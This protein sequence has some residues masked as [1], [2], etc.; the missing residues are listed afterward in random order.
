MNQTHSE[1]RNS[2][3]SVSSM[4][5]STN[6]AT[7]LLFSAKRRPTS[8]SSL[9]GI[10]DDSF[11]VIAGYMCHCF[12]AVAES[13]LLQNWMLHYRIAVSQNGFVCEYPQFRLDYLWRPERVKLFTLNPLYQTK[14]FFFFFCL[15]KFTAKTMC[16]KNHLLLPLD[17]QRTQCIH[18]VSSMLAISV[19]FLLICI[20]HGNI[21]FTAVRCSRLMWRYRYQLI[22]WHAC[23]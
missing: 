10:K 1:K 12:C 5:N 6:E 2:S 4:L 18:L 14:D 17:W 9:L 21:K 23:V 16:C 3:F 19:N 11:T 13:F 15:L 22:P 8:S 7:V 20:V